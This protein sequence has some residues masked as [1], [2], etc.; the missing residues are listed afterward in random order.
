[1]C[2]AVDQAQHFLEDWRK[3]VLEYKIDLEGKGASKTIPSRYWNTRWMLMIS[4][5]WILSMLI[6]NSH[7]LSSFSSALITEGI[8][9]RFTHAYYKAEFLVE[10]CCIWLLYWFVWSSMERNR[11]KIRKLRIIGFHGSK[12]AL[13]CTIRYLTVKR[14]SRAE[15]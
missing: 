12:F 13:D 1:M 4:A 15:R 11:H 8:V 10:N 6:R 2:F 14:T 3:N 5:A 9:F 7:E